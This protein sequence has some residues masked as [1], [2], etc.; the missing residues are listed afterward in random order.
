[1]KRMIALLA[2]LALTLSL[3]A[4]GGTEQG[5]TQKPPAAPS[6]SV[7]VLPD[8]PSPSEEPAE[9]PEPS[10]NSNIL[11]AYFTWAD[12]TVVEDP[13]AVDV[14]ATTSA[15]VLI[16]GNTAIMAQFIQQQV[17]GD[18]FS[19]RVT[20]PY[21]SDYDEC[22]DRAADEKAENA[23]PEL[24]ET[25]DNM[26][27]YDIV[28]LGFPNWWYTCPM[29]IF[30]FVEQHDLSGKTVI[31][32]VVHGTGGLS[33]TIR[34]LTAALPEDA[35]VLEPV[36]IYRDDMPQAE[37]TISAWLDGLGVDFSTGPDAEAM[38][39][40][41]AMQMT[42][43]VDG[44]EISVTLLDNPTARSLWEQL[45]LTL[46]FED[47]NGTEKIAYPPEE[48]SQEGAPASYDPSAGDVAVYGPWGNI[49]IFYEDFGDSA[50][51]IPIGHIDAGLEILS[52]Q[53]GDFT[54]VL[55]R[56]A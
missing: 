25:V 45:P 29:V 11:I 44:Q 47:Y 42:I 4:C 50:G 28:F 26:A 1:M 31:P 39:E 13:N 46:T 40:E 36:G 17:G 30:S 53:A 23:R 56:A 7:E 8:T 33:S 34:D 54:A 32:F 2:A 9:S 3:T 16:P 43:T 10:G 24:A 52:G 27:D 51:L 41:T 14:D 22:L 21:S 6:Q 5:E 15:S 18:L 35:A 19:I 37:G 20:E 12:N 48:L 55:E 38:Q 49:S